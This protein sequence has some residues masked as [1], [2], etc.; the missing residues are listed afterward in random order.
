MHRM[1]L[2]RQKNKTKMKLHLWLIVILSVA[3]VL[4]MIRISSLNDKVSDLEQAVHECV[5]HEQ[6]QSWQRTQETFREGG[7]S[8]LSQRGRQTPT[9]EHQ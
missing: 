9:K 3:L 8:A 1:Q 5:T 7:R 2:R 4:F 6:F